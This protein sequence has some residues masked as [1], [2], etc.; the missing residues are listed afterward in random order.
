MPRSRFLPKFQGDVCKFTKIFLYFTCQLEYSFQSFFL[1]FL[2]DFELD[3]DHSTR[4][5]CEHDS[6][7]NSAIAMVFALPIIFSVFFL[8]F[9][10]SPA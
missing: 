7:C 10:I 6:T 1:L 5:M 2:F 9:Y 4:R 8:Y 3:V